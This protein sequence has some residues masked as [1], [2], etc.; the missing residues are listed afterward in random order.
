MAVITDVGT[1]ADIHPKH[2]EPV[3]QRLALLAR[4]IAY[5]EKIEANGPVFRS[6]SVRDGKA[7][8]RFS[9]VGTGLKALAV[10]EEGISVPA[11]KTV[12]FTIAGKDGVFYNADAVIEG[13]ETVVVS[14]PQVPE[15]TNIRFGWANFPVVNLWNSDGLP[16][17]PFRTDA[18][19]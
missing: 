8:L 10:E 7:V 5:G 2:K 16:A 11:G 3:G 1:A 13:K 14:S 15:P 17:S 9:S 12:G 18:P 4:N 19:K 6:M